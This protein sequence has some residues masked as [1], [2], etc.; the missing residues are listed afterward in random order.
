LSIE[1]P[2]NWWGAV[3]ASLAVERLASR[4][5]DQAESY[6]VSYVISNEQITINSLPE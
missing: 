6:P 5:V 3:A 4:T 2:A 1:L